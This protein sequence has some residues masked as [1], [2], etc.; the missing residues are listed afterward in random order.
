MRSKEQA[1]TSTPATIFRDW[2]VVR[3]AETGVVLSHGTFKPRM[4]GFFPA[5][6]TYKEVKDLS[7]EGGV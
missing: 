5:N 1:F 2:C 3:R 6:C 7:K 4:L